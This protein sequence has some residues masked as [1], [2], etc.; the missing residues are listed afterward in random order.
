MAPSEQWR[1]DGETLVRDLTFADFTEAMAFNPL[2]LSGQSNNV[3]LVRVFPS[4]K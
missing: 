2:S 4:A 3:R 1:Q